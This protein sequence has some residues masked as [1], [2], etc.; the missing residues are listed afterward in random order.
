MFLTRKL[1]IVISRYSMEVQ[2][3]SSNYDAAVGETTAVR[4]SHYAVLNDIRKF[5]RQIML[6]RKDL[7]RRRG[8]AILW[9]VIRALQVKSREWIFFNVRDYGE[10]T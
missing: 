6:T 2:R 5:L 7:H 8:A 1:L 4:V 9:P 3:P 10:S